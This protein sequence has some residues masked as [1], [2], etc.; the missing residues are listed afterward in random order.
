MI[1]DP[2]TDCQKSNS[3]VF[4]G[5]HVSEDIAAP[6]DTIVEEVEEE[7]NDGNSNGSSDD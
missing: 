1:E 4:V 3:N 5:E 2:W 7:N 6:P